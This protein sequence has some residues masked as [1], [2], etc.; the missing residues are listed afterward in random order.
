MASSV[1]P[2]FRI[3]VSINDLLLHSTAHPPAPPQPKGATLPEPVFPQYPELLSVAGPATPPEKRQWTREQLM[4]KVRGWLGPYIRSR[5]MPGDFH[6]ITA[7]LFVEYKCN[8]DCWYCWSFNNKVK[9]MTEDVAR[10]SIDWL[11]DHGCRVLALMGGEPLLRPQV[12]HKIVYYAAKRGFWV[13]IATNGR[14][15]RPEVTDRLADAGTA[16]FNFALDAWDE[17][18]ACLRPSSRPARTSGI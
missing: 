9:G 17:K 15:L 3:D 5:V 14:L 6:P 2:A 10:R 8:I 1:Q 16:V 11:H 4:R 18:L 13:Y 7:Y 12:V